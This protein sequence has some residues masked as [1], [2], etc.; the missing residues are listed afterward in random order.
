[1]DTAHIVIGP[2]GTIL[3]ASGDLPANLVDAPLEDCAQLPR[4]VRDAGK[5][6]LQRLPQA[7]GRVAREDVTLDD[8]GSRVQLLAIE[9]CA[10]R[11]RATDLRALL[12]SKLTVIS[13]QALSAQVTLRIV[14][15]GDVPALVRVDSEKVAWAVTTLVGNAL[16][17]VTSGSRQ[18]P[19]ETID[20]RA[21]FDPAIGVTIEVQDNGPG[22][23]AESVARLFKRDGLNVLGS[24]LALLVMSDLVAGHGGRLD[25]RSSTDAA[26]HGTTVRLTFPAA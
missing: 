6:L 7:P 26:A 12:A 19:G 3:A 4:R 5:A 25:V 2:D 22:I 13:S 17:Y 18:K 24:G 8:G 21:S 16:R 14:V 15:A 9:A 23:P 20:V 11:R 1:M 10:I